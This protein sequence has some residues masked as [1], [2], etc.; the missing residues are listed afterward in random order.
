MSGIRWELLVEDLA[1]DCAGFTP[2]DIM[3]A[4]FKAPMWK[5][6]WRSEAAGNNNR[7]DVLC[8]HCG[9]KQKALP[10]R[11]YRHLAKSCKKTP[12]SVRR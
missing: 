11:M 12:M 6:F 4:S 2:I 3:A 10:D 1:A 8:L 7:H 9:A 5:H